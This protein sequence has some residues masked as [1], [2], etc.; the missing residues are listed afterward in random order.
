MRL[1]LDLPGMMTGLE[2]NDNE[3]KGQRTACYFLDSR[4]GT[5][6]H[7]GAPTPI[8]HLLPCHLLLP[9]Q[10]PSACAVS[11][12]YKSSNHPVLS[13]PLDVC[14]AFPTGWCAFPHTQHVKMN[15]GPFPPKPSLCQGLMSLLLF[16]VCS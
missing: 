5:S 4:P 15:Y 6:I 2:Q 10:I 9:L 11:S 7:T 16:A 13:Y 14:K 3:E 12:I 1:T 8:L